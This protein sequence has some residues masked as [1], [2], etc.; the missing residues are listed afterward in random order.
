MPCVITSN[1]VTFSYALGLHPYE[2][3][4]YL[5]IIHEVLVVIPQAVQGCKMRP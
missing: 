5:L 3:A 2:G 4:R 1:I